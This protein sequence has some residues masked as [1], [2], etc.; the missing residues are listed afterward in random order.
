MV[1]KSPVSKPKATVTKLPK[2]S[3][4]VDE[5]ETFGAT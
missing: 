2:M 3:E 5:G 4:Y 1:F